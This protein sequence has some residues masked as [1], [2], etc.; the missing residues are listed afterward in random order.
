LSGPHTIAARVF[1]VVSA[2]CLVS[3]FALASLFSPKLSLGEL[4]AM[5]DQR[6]L[7]ATQTFVRNS[8]SP[9]LWSSVAMPILLRP[10]WL[11]P[12]CLGLVTTGISLTLSTKPGPARSRRRS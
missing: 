6:A 10:A 3:A 2:I 1:A 7:A 5:A 4:A 8:L 12:L 9:W 11:L